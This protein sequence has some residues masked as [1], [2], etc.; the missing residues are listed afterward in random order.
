[1][2]VENGFGHLKARFRREKGIDNT[3]ENSALVIKACCVLHNF[4]NNRNDEVTLKWLVAQQQVD[5]RRPQPAKDVLLRAADASGEEIREAIAVF[6]ARGVKAVDVDGPT[7]DE[8]DCGGAGV[9][10]ADRDSNASW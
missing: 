1:M 9:D 2:V 5:A 4:L 3:I 6:L 10:G 8:P 7:G